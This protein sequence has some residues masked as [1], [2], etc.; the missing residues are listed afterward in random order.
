[1]GILP[2]APE[3][4]RGKK[5]K[6]ERKCVM[7]WKSMNAAAAVQQGGKSNCRKTILNIT[8]LQ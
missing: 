2:L 8:T 1:M 5:K 6:K 4:E 3:K 7:F